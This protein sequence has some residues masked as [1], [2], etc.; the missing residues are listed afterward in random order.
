MAID[1]LTLVGMQHILR[2]GFRKFRIFEILNLCHYELYDILLCL[3]QRVSDIIRV[4]AFTRA[5]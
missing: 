3:N 5:N 2:F 4:H 1:H